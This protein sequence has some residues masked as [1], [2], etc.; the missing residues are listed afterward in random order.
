MDEKS[1]F[2]VRA[3]SCFDTW[4]VASCVLFLPL[5]PGVLVTHLRGR[6]E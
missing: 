5:T 1:I 3:V 4:T 2:P 6:F